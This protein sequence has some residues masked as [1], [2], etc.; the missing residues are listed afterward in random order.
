MTII[1]NSLLALLCCKYIRDRELLPIKSLKYHMKVFVFGALMASIVVGTIFIFYINL[2]GNYN[3]AFFSN[4]QVTAGFIHHF[5]VSLF[6]ESLFRGIILIKINKRM[7][8]TLAIIISSIIFTLPHLVHQPSHAELLSIFLGGILLASLVIKSR[9]LG[10]AV[11]FHLMWNILSMQM[12]NQTLWD[13]ISICV[14]LSTICA[15]H[16]FYAFRNRNIGQIP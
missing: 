8:A 2:N 11:G 6:E 13:F 7:P 12:P 14:L 10:A 16:I 9:S 1:A 5:F 15:I 4:L 3:F